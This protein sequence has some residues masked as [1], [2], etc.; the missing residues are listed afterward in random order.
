MDCNIFM[1]CRW[2]LDAKFQKTPYCDVRAA[3]AASDL[4]ARGER[5][6]CPPSTESTLDAGVGEEREGE[7]SGVTSLSANG[8]VSPL[9]RGGCNV[10]LQNN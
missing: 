4:E 3:A 2:R 8:R 5:G 1:C 10:Q 9:A 7:G 6:G